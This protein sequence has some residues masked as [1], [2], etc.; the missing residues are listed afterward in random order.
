MIPIYTLGPS[1]AIIAQVP[2]YE[3]NYW[4][5][6]QAEDV[7]KRLFVF[8]T[9]RKVSH[10]QDYAGFYAQSSA[11]AD[12]SNDHFDD[13]R[14][15]VEATS[16][17]HENAIMVEN[18]NNTMGISTTL[19]V[20]EFINGLGD[21]P[22]KAENLTAIA[23]ANPTQ[24]HLVVPEDSDIQSVHDLKGKVVNPGAKGSG[25]ETSV[26]SLLLPLGLSS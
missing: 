23:Y 16:G 14:F 1:G 26:P 3:E 2:E 9:V 24:L 18:Q 10:D 22:A 13:F 7:L 12:L 21:F 25:T 20:Y 19:A 6:Y 8:P 11:L 17:G 15:T 4:M 5:K